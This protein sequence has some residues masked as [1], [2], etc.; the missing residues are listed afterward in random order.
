M[1]LGNPDSLCPPRAHR[2]SLLGSSFRHRAQTNQKQKSIL[3]LIKWT[4]RDQRRFEEKL[5]RLKCLIDGLEVVARSYGV[6]AHPQFQTQESPN[7]LEHP[8]PY[9]AAVAS[10]PSPIL[11]MGAFGSEDASTSGIVAIEHQEGSGGSRGT[12]NP[13]NES[14]VP[15]PVDQSGSVGANARSSATYNL[16]VDLFHQ[17]VALKRYL[18]SIGGRESHPVARAQEK[19]TQLSTNSFNDLFA[20]I[21]DELLRRQQWKQ[22]YLQHLHPLTQVHPNRN[23]ARLKLSNLTSSRFGDLVGDTVP[24][25][26]RRYPHIQGVVSQISSPAVPSRILSLTHRRFSTRRWGHVPPHAEDAPPPLLRYRAPHRA[27]LNT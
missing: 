10:L 12:P 13:R 4:I 21:Y 1:R 26:E 20:D 25:F 3:A 8:P 7:Q 27:A 17:H 5:K 23:A 11:Y 19:L 6:P 15:I 14:N 22:P 9:S 24:E 18:V 2:L 16:I